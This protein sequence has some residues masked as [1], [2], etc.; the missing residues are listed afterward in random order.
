MA[1]T[2]NTTS[3]SELDFIP[4]FVNLINTNTL[5]LRS[6]IED[7]YN[8]LVIDTNLA[9]IGSQTTPISALISRSISLKTTSNGTDGLFFTDSNNNIIGSIQNIAGKIVASFDEV[10]AKSNLTLYTISTIISQKVSNVASVLIPLVDNGTEDIIVNIKLDSSSFTNI[11]S[12]SS[13]LVDGIEI[14]FVFDSIV[15]AVD[16][17]TFNI[18]IGN[19]VDNN[20]NIVSAVLPVNGIKLVQSTAPVLN[21][22]GIGNLNTILGVSGDL[23][24]LNAYNRTVTLKVV[25]INSV[26]SLIIK[27]IS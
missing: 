11:G 13:Y 1:Y 10:I 5:K 19:I 6:A 21:N 27:N 7:V 18:T 17:E 3:L 22:I 9:T 16:G 4:D 25:T 8:N 23:T 15:P 2:V 12:P 20:G 14:G 26:K 24:N